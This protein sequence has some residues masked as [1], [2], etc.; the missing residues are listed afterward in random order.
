MNAVIIYQQI[1]HVTVAVESVFL[2]ALLFSP[3]SLHS[4]Y[5]LYSSSI[6]V[7]TKGH[8]SSHSIYSFRLLATTYKESHLQP[9]RGLSRLIIFVL[10]MYRIYVFQVSDNHFFNWGQNLLC[11]LYEIL[12]G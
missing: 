3:V 10:M 9:M 12:K 1:E 5:D 11:Y 8:I 2:L 6:K 4:C 7:G